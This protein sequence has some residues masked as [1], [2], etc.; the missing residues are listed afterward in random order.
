M[1][2][3][4]TLT[5]DLKIILGFITILATCIVAV[6]K[7]PQQH[8]I[9]KQAGAVIGCLLGFGFGIWLIVNGRKKLK[10]YKKQE[11]DTRL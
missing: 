4:Q 1:N 8:G 11:T 5:Q 3:K 10:Q 2:D 6:W 9:P 7:I